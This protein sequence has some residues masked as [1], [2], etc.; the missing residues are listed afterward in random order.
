MTNTQRILLFF[1]LP[2]LAPLVYSPDILSG[3]FASG[4]SGGIITIVLVAALFVGLGFLLLRGRSAALTLSIFLQGLN[5]II[6]TMMLLSKFTYS[7]GSI[8]LPYMIAAL[9]SIGV[10][11][12]LVLRL[13][14]VD[15]RTAMVR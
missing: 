11:L 5:V 12:Y 1:V 15:V 7:D 8:N 10:S 9:I 4:G 6:R 14:R 13:D 2:T 3:I